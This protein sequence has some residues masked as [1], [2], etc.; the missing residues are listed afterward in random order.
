MTPPSR[1]IAVVGAGPKGTYALDCLARELSAGRSPTPVALHVFEPHPWPGAGPV[2][3]PEQPAFLRIN[4]ANRNIDMW[5]SDSDGPSFV[6]WLERHSPQD[7]E[8][9]HSAPRALVGRYLDEG[10]R[11]IISRLEAVA[12]V[13]LRSEAVIDIATTEQGWQVRTA[14]HTTNV[15]EVLITTGHRSRS[16]EP[17]PLAG[18]GYIDSVYPISGSGI[19]T[20]RPGS[21]VAVR[22]LGLTAIDAILALT[23]GRGG[24]FEYNGTDPIPTYRAGGLEPAVLVPYSRTGLLMTPKPWRDDD[25]TARHDRTHLTDALMAS[26]DPV[27]TLAA[28]IGV[29]SF[30]SSPSQAT[31]TTATGRGRAFCDEVR[32]A[33]DPDRT[34]AAARLGSTWRRLYPSIVDAVHL[35]CFDDHWAR[36]HEM[37]V[38]MERLAFGPPA[39]N[40]ARIAALVA[41]GVIDLRFAQDPT[42]TRSAAGFTLRSAKDMIVVDFVCNA[43]LPSAGV[44]DDATA[45]ISGLLHR[46]HLRLHP[47]GGIDVDRYARALDRHGR[48]TRG[49]S[50][51]GRMTQGATLGND[52]LSRT[53]HNYPERWA[54]LC[55]IAPERPN[56]VVSTHC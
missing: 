53:L 32:A 9:D 45:P 34:T 31:P 16:P 6:D 47:S 23:E 43:V 30:D 20:I 24:N 7:A 29:D 19:E 28:V 22:G 37:T 5:A 36:F 3:D 10:F 38:R 11:T 46:G 51:I 4:Y 26:F 48:P 55:T 56:H 52:T 35:R 1:S 33:Y 2:Y 12:T 25:S 50:V 17:S 13:H 40:A 8:P 15:D 44:G 42:V 21:R 14:E 39:P 49:L 27:G 54:R 18:D 41:A